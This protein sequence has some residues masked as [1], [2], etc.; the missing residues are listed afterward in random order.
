MVILVLKSRE[1][2]LPSRAC[3]QKFSEIIIWGKRETSKTPG[4]LLHRRSALKQS[5]F[6]LWADRVSWE[7]SKCS[8]GKCHTLW[9]RP[10]G[11]CSLTLTKPFPKPVLPCWSQRGIQNPVQ[12]AEIRHRAQA[13]SSLSDSQV[14]TGAVSPRVAGCGILRRIQ[15]L[16]PE[17]YD[18]LASLG[19]C[20]KSES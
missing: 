3:P 15:D 18:D 20:W 6:S 7:N 8:L 1:W 11:P 9:V 5:L 12:E 2:V 19:L 17:T 16:D 13:T 4:C 14:R 10:K